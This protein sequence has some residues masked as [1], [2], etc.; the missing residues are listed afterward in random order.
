MDYNGLA[1]LSQEQRQVA[2]A[3]FTDLILS[4]QEEARLDGYQQG[5]RDANLAPDSSEKAERDAEVKRIVE[6]KREREEN[7]AHLSADP[8]NAAQHRGAARA[9][10]EILRR[11]GLEAD[12]D[13]E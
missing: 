11:L 9:C 1:Y 7:A 10:D 8:I 2:L 13:L 6:V 3:Q 4:V 12:D 5:V